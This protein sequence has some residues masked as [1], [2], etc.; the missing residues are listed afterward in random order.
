MDSPT[1]MARSG[2]EPTGMIAM[3]GSKPNDQPVSGQVRRSTIT[4]SEASRVT[5]TASR[6]VRDPQAVPFPGPR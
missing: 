6:F 5:L 1:M 2:S 4:K 3:T